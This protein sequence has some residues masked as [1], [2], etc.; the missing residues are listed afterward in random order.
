[1]AHWFDSLRGKKDLN[2]VLRDAY[3]QVS[4]ALDMEDPS[5]DKLGAALKPL[6]AALRALGDS[7]DFWTAASSVPEGKSQKQKGAFKDLNSF[8]HAEG[9]WIKQ[10]V[11]EDSSLTDRMKQDLQTAVE[12]SLAEPVS[13]AG[14]IR[15]LRDQVREFAREVCVEEAEFAKLSKEQRRARHARWLG[16]AKKGAMVIAGATMVV[17]DAAAATQAVLTP[18]GIVLLALCELSGE[19]GVDI[20]KSQFPRQG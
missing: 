16:F 19:V 20:V 15:I 3:R 13:A 18:G 8:L 17:A 7:D 2:T 12:P 9:E 4:T 11:L 10:H 14:T 1:M 5:A 6:C